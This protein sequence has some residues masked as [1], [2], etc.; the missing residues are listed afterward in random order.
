[1]SNISATAQLKGM[2]L[3]AVVILYYRKT[4]AQPMQHPT[5]QSPNTTRSAA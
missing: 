3:E 4:H 5:C 2:M 1:M